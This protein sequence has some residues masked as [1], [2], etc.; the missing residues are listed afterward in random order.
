MDATVELLHRQ[1]NLLIL[2]LPWLLIVL[3][4]IVLRRVRTDGVVHYVGN[5]SGCAL[6]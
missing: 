2:A 5:S 4:D 1:R 6:S 3:A